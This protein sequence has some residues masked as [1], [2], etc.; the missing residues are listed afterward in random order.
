MSRRFHPFSL[1]CEVACGGDHPKR[2]LILLIYP[3]H[4]A[5]D[6]PYPDRSIGPILFALDHQLY[7]LS[8]DQ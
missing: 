7:G 4:E 8:F 1:F 5:T 3:I 2:A 6:D